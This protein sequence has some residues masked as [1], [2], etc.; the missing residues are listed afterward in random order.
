MHD[1]LC[2][3][4]S[5]PVSST[6][7]SP[8]N[9]RAINQRVINQRATNR[10]TSNQLLT[11]Q[12]FVTQNYKNPQLTA[13]AGE[14]I[15]HPYPRNVNSRKLSSAPRFCS[16]LQSENVVPVVN[17]FNERVASRAGQYL[18][19]SD[20]TQKP[21]DEEFQ[22]WVSWRRAVNGHFAKSILTQPDPAELSRDREHVTKQ[23]PHPG[24][25]VR[26]FQ[27]AA[28]GRTTSLEQKTYILFGIPRVT[29][30]HLMDLANQTQPSL[31]RL[32]I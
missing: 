21:S 30:L 17:Q 1:K 13:H 29:R 7:Q 14:V 18:K 2:C 28:G 26:V 5:K 6:E 24:T 31:K 15:P 22:E 27:E 20:F 23:Q 12:R 4:R 16:D 25:M 8:V 11:N 9:Q 19:T 3:I 32:R 10:R